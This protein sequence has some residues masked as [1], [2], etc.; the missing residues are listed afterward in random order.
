MRF[1]ELTFTSLLLRQQF[2]KIVFLEAKSFFWPLEESR[3]SPRMEGGTTRHSRREGSEQPRLDK[4][5]H[6]KRVRVVSV[7]GEEGEGTGNASLNDGKGRH[8]KRRKSEDFKKL[9]RDLEEVSKVVQQHLDELSRCC[10]LNLAVA[11]T[12]I[13]HKLEHHLKQ[14]HTPSEEELEMVLKLMPPNSTRESAQKVRLPL[15]LP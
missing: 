7:H 8:R 6:K 13:L 1:S 3:Q 9:K 10:G 14:S 2:L 4:S 11:R 5:G 15:Q 12:E